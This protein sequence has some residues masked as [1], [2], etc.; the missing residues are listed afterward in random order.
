MRKLFKSLYSRYVI[1]KRRKALLDL[2]R[3]FSLSIYCKEDKDNYCCEFH[4][5]A[6]YGQKT[7]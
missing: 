4:K 2:K 7:K 6:G 3:S 5:K 1:Y